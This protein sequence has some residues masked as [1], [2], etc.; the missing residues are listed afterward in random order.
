MKSS[1]PCSNRDRPKSWRWLPFLSVI[2]IR[3]PQQV[4]HDG[5]VVRRKRI[6]SVCNSLDFFPRKSLDRRDAV[7]H[8][9]RSASFARQDNLRIRVAAQIC[10][11]SIPN[12]TLD[13]CQQQASARGN[14]S[15]EQRKVEAARLFDSIGRKLLELLVAGID[16]DSGAVARV[17]LYRVQFKIGSVGSINMVRIRNR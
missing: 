16:T 1:L 12:A 10:P 4:R 15:S 6:E 3:E 13:H 8:L 9:D 5:S 17:S 11:A 2:L 7:R 14:Q